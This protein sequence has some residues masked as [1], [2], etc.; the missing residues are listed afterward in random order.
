VAPDVLEEKR[1]GTARA[2]GFD[3][4]VVGYG[5]DAVAGPYLLGD[6]YRGPRPSSTNGAASCCA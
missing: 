3:V 1:G 6:N 5:I 4:H 2:D